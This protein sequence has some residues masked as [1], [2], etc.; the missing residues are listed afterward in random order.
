M[1]TRVGMGVRIEVGMRVWVAVGM[2]EKDWSGE[3]GERPGNKPPPR[4][5]F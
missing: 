5:A 4:P 3:E 2:G 1:T